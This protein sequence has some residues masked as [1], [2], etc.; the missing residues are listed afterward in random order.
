MSAFVYILAHPTAPRFNIGKAI[1]VLTRIRQIGKRQFDLARS[2][3]VRVSTEKE[4]HNIERLLHRVFAKFRVSPEVVTA[5]EGKRP[6]GATEWFDTACQARLAQFLADNE[7]LLGYA[8]LDSKQLSTLVHPPK[9]PKK[10]G[11]EAKLEKAEKERLRQEELQA[12]QQ[13]AREFA[14]HNIA[15][16]AARADKVLLPAIE[17]LFQEC[18]ML[19]LVP[20]ERGGSAHLVGACAGPQQ[21]GVR[22]ALAILQRMWFVGKSDA[23]NM[24]TG[25]ASATIDGKLSFAVR[26]VWP[27]EDHNTLLIEGVR[28]HIASYPLNIPGWRAPLSDFDEIQAQRLLSAL[29]LPQ[30]YR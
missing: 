1:D 2:F 19:Y 4:A 28:N 6:D 18:E 13:R 15:A 10:R 3:A 22:N 26:L 17:T 11:K 9:A 20:A 27:G 29:D 7:D 5:S 8:R 14:P 25:Q 12:K 16:G 30:A 21:P 24:T 23:M